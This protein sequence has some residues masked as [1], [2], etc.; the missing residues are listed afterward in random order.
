MPGSSHERRISGPL[1]TESDTVF[2]QRL[3]IDGSTAGPDEGATGLESLRALAQ[4]LL[5]LPVSQV[6]VTV[7]CGFLKSAS[8]N[9]TISCR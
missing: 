4:E 7:T 5:A 1:S 8:F 9:E 6:P 3:L 2:N